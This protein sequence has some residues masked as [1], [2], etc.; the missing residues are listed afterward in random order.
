MRTDFST[1]TRDSALTFKALIERFI[2][3]D[4]GLGPDINRYIS[5]Q[6]YIQG[7]PSLSGNPESGGLGEPRYNIDRT[8]FMSGWGRPQRDGPA[9]R[10]TALILYANWL[11]DHGVR[12][13]ALQN[14]WPVISKDLQYTAHYWNQTGFDLWEETTGSSFFTLSANHRALV[15]GMALATRLG[16]S[17]NECSDAAPKVLCFLQTFWKGTYIESN[18]NTQE[19]FHRTGKDAN[20]ILSSIHTFDPNSGCIDATFQPCSARALANHKAVVDSFRSVY[21]IN[22]GIPQGNAVAV[23]R[24]S[25]DA[26][27]NGNP[28]YLITSAAAE[29]LYDAMHQWKLQGE[30]TITDV[31]LPFFQ[32]LAPSITTGTYNFGSP[33]YS[34]ITDAVRSYADGFIEIVKKY[35]PSNGELAE[36][37][38]RNNGLP[39]SAGDL[40]WSYAAFL[41]ATSRRAGTMG[42]SWGESSSNQVPSTCSRACSAKITFNLHTSVGSGEK[43]YVIGQLDQLHNWNADKP[44]IL[45][46]GN[47]VW[48]VQVDVPAGAPFE[49]KYIKKNSA[50]QTTWSSGSNY[51]FKQQQECGGVGTVDDEVIWE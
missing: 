47:S 4:E 48:S 27:Y 22:N 28:W 17:C 37:F 42:P 29:Q 8:A 11:V 26:Y 2:D 12:I 43:V 24:Y 19:S 5:A 3:G 21:S 6:A 46:F 51:V 13:E 45:S 1:W 34:T 49:Y 50:G 38:D 14:V 9:L 40:T 30:I 10:A 16:Q 23:G 39:L 18:I 41:T 31:S 32:D 7:I 35:T 20:S 15:E 25:E 33:T 36:Q 44:V